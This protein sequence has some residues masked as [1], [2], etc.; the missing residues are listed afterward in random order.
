MSGTESLRYLTD[1]EEDMV[2]DDPD[3]PTE[4]SLEC[5]DCERTF[6]VERGREECPNCLGL[7]TVLLD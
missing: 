6:I 4:V 2:L 7:N 1:A 3:E 5:R